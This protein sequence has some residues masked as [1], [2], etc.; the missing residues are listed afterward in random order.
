[1]D[2]YDKYVGTIIINNQE[3]TEESTK[4]HFIAVFSMIAIAYRIS[5][6]GKAILESQKFIKRREIHFVE[7][8]YPN[9]CFFEAL[10]YLS[11]PDSKI[12]RYR[13]QNRVAEGIRLIIQHYS[14]SGNS[15]KCREIQNFL[16][17]FKGFDLAADD[18][19]IAKRL[20]INF[21]VYAFQEDDNAHILFVSDPE[22]LTGYRY[23]PIYK[24]HVNEMFDKFRLTQYYITYDFET[25]ERNINKYFGKKKDEKNE[26]VATTIKSKSG[27]KTIYSDLHYRNFIEKLLGEVFKA[28]EQIKQ[29]NMYQD[30]EVSYEIPVPVVGFNSTHFDMIFVLPYLSNKDWHIVQGGYLGD[31]SHIMRVEVRHKIGNVK[32]QFLD[33]DT[34]MTLKEAAESFGDGNEGTYHEIRNGITGG[35]ANGFDFN[36]LYPSVCSGLQH[37]FIRYCGHQIQSNNVRSI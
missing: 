32:I 7:S 17:D 11:M 37:E 4:H 15:A 29:D 36:S 35:L 3:R 28:A 19:K 26:T 22:A 31:F 13:S 16:T 1:M 8:P 20:N 10:S 2:T 25:V 9:N 18:K 14:L 30:L 24:L 5:F 34:F 6:A 12:N 23:C 21:C 27:I 33:I